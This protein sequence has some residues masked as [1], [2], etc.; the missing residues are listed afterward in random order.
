MHAWYTYANKL[1]SISN[2]LMCYTQ[3]FSER[4]KENTKTNGI[5]EDEIFSRYTTRQNDFITN[6]LRNK[7]WDTSRKT[8]LDDVKWKEQQK[9]EAD[10]G[11]DDGDGGEASRATSTLLVLRK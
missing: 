11:D 10:L 3:T 2:V 7:R 5:Q 1:M 6:I 4:Y 8:Y 9:S